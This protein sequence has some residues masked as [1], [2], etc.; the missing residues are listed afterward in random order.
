MVPMV[1]K[2]KEGGSMAKEHDLQGHKFFWDTAIIYLNGKLIF[3]A[4]NI[5][6]WEFKKY[7]AIKIKTTLSSVTA[8]VYVH[9]IVVHG[10]YFGKYILVH[11]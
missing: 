11:I 8:I 2:E 3:L 9:T 1:T 6:R 10:A 7:I 4:L 5:D